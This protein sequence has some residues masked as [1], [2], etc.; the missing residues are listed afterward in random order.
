MVESPLY[1]YICRMDSAFKDL[2]SRLED[3]VSTSISV[4]EVSPLI[5]R[6]DLL[7]HDLMINYY[8]PESGRLNEAYTNFEKRCIHLDEDIWLNKGRLVLNRI[9]NKIGQT[10]RIHARKGVVARIDKRTTIDFL[11]EHHLHA[12]LPGKYRYGLFVNGEL[13]SIAVFSG[14]RL[15][16]HTKGYRSFECIRFCTKQC[17]NIVG[18]LSKLLKAFCRDFNP[19]DIMTY[20]DRDW[21]NGNSYEKMGFERSGKTAPQV[22]V[23]DRRSHHRIP[24]TSELA[25]ALTDECSQDSY[26]VA[27]SGS[28]KMIKP[29]FD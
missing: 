5:Y 27:N 15:M 24:Y 20:V 9:L 21:S 16:R 7:N 25:D 4:V 10:Q 14:A 12:P 13:L 2:L 17:Y 29:Y 19:N 22:Y 28:L 1:R 23:V 6:V 11:E 3:K 18:G 26:L 8:L